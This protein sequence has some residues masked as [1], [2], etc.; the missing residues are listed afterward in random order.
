MS[1]IISIQETTPM[2]KD[3]LFGDNSISEREEFKNL[4]GEDIRNAIKLIMNNP[5]LSDTEKNYFINNAWKINYAI[6][7]PTVDEF[8]TTQWLGSVGDQ[9][10]PHVRSVMR[11]FLDPMSEKRVLALST[12]IGFGKSFLA[13]LIAVYIIVHVAYMRNPKQFYGLNEAGSLVVAL[14]SF[15]KEKVG[16]I[17]LQPFANL[18]KASP[19]FEKTVREDRLEQK[20]KEIDPTHIAYTSSGRMGSFQFTHDIHITTLSDRAA[21]LGLNIILGIASEISFWIKKGISVDEIWGTFTDL[22]ERVNS[23]FHSRYLSGVILDSSPL[24]LSISP[25]DKWIYEGEA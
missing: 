13:S 8:L 23:R 17:L 20:Q 25:I 3:L 12:C 16:Q 21:L 11:A 5:I 7:P 4:T 22:R 6:K 19:M 14:A 9:I 2:I 18:L 24:D 10:Y 15:T 1:S